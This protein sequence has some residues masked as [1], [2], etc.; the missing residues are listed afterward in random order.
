METFARGRWRA[1]SCVV[2]GLGTDTV[3]GFNGTAEWQV[4]ALLMLGVP[5][6]R[7]DAT[8][9]SAMWPDLAPSMVPVGLLTA[10]VRVCG[11][12]FART[13]LARRGVVPVVY[14]VDAEVP[15]FISPSEERTRRG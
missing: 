13:P 14:T 8:A 1:G 3:V 9:R 6:D 11:Q 2:C 15:T 7:V 12:C 4:A 5:A 10:V